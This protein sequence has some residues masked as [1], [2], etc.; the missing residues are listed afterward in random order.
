MHGFNISQ[1]P[2]QNKPLD[3]IYMGTNRVK[4]LQFIENQ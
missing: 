2:K 1:K 3:V 4:T